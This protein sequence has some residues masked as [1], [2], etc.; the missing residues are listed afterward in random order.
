MKRIAAI[1]LPVLV[2][3]LWCGN[4]F[5]EEEKMVNISIGQ[6]SAAAG[7][8]IVLEVKID[9]NAGLSFLKLQ[10]EY[11]STQLTLVAAKNNGVFQ[12]MM[13]SGSQKI[14]V[15]PYSLVWLNASN[16]EENGKIAEL[17]FRVQENAVT[18]EE[19]IKFVYTECCD[20]NTAAIKVQTQDGKI[21]IK[22]QSP[23]TDGIHTNTPTPEQGTAGNSASLNTGTT[24]TPTAGCSTNAPTSETPDH[25]PTAS[26]AVPVPGNNTAAAQKPG[27]SKEA[28]KL[29]FLLLLV[30]PIG[31]AAY[32]IIYKKKKNKSN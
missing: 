26:T 5:A 1:I 2:C 11:D 16:V 10:V 24:S 18:K 14:G 22:G 9:G 12:G 30:I 8:T 27:D 7:D 25:M 15:N 32:Y 19:T 29:W 28:G 17:T 13:Y 4:V 23:A 3:L 31:G 20:M 6:A 21:A